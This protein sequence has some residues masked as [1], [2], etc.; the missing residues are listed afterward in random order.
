MDY[1]LE[2]FNQAFVDGQ[3]FLE[4]LRFAELR[5]SRDLVEY[6]NILVMEKAI[7]AAKVYYDK[8][9]ELVA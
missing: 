1:K 7:A 3:S 6:W 5:R 8:L 9:L 2:K 4:A